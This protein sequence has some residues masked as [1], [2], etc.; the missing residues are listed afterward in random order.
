MS[1]PLSEH[2]TQR[3][4][5]KWLRARRH[6]VAAVPNEQAAGPTRL[7][8]YLAEGMVP[9]FPDLLVLAHGVTPPRWVL[10]EVKA[11]GGVLSDKQRRVHRALARRGVSVLVGYGLAELKARCEGVGL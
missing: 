9:G 8:K 11:E 3:K 1:E 6:V 4:L 2:A 7:G 5:V 10:I